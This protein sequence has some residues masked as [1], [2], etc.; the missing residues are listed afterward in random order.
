M[1]GLLA[2]CQLEPKKRTKDY[3]NS[4]YISR[5]MGTRSGLDKSTRFSTSAT[6]DMDLFSPALASKSKIPRETSLVRPASR[7]TWSWFSVRL[8]Q[9]LPLTARR[10]LFSKCGELLLKQSIEESSVCFVQDPP[11]KIRAVLLWNLDAQQACREDNAQ[12]SDDLN[13]LD[14]KPV[15]PILE[16]SSLPKFDM[17]LYKSSLTE[18]HVK[19]LAKCYGIPTDLHPRV[20]RLSKN[21]KPCLK[22]APTSMKKWKDKFFLV[23]R[24]AAL[25][26]MAWRHHDSS[27]ADPF[28]KP[29]EYDASDVVKLR[30]VVISLRKPPPSLLYVT[31]LSNIWKHAS[32]VFSLKDS[33]GKVVIMAEFLQLPNFK[34]YKVAA[35]AILPHGSAL[36]THLASPTERLEDLPPKTRDMVIAEIPCRKT[37]RVARNKD[38]GKEGARKKRRVRVGT[39]VHPDSEHGVQE[40]VDAAFSNE[41]HGDNEGGQHPEIVEKPVRDKSAQQQ[42]NTLLCFEALTEEHA[43]LFYAHESCKDVKARYKECKK[44]LVKVQSAYDEKASAYDQLSKNYEGALTREKSLQD[45]LEELEEETKEKYVV[46]A[47]AFILAIDKGFIDGISIGR[48]DPDIQAI[49]KATPNVNPAS[50]DIFMETYEKLFDKRY[51]YVDKVARMYL[52]DPSGLQ[53]VMPDETG[54]TPSGGPCDTPTASYA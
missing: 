17:H 51:P 2:F 31:G 35:G 25:I 47:E 7:P 6:E 23:D 44:E 45:R 5:A 19:W 4:L 49:L 52:L 10:C 37:K 1:W 46:E 48:K 41:G 9:R 50:S 13:I 54:P 40:N 26:A 16:A 53:N 15:D 34:G 33:K 18:T 20:N 30:E 14:A 43:N 28:P 8:P 21:C 42:T 11:G 38:A 29:S 32:H 22:D 3:Q 39:P 36:V 24:R 12:E 27:I